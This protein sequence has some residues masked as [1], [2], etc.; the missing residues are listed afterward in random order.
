MDIPFISE[1]DIITAFARLNDKKFVYGPEENGGV[2][3]IGI[4]APYKNGIFKKIRWSTSNSFNDL[5]V[6]SGEKNTFSLKLKNDLNLPEDILSLKD[7]ISHNC[8]IL[9]NFLC[10]SGY[11]FSVKN[12]YVNFDDL[13]I[14]IPVV[15]NIIQK[16]KKGEIEILIQTRYKP[17]FDPENTGKLEIPSGLIKKNELAQEAAVRE[18]EEETGIISEVS[19]EQEVLDYIVSKK[20]N[21]VAVYKPFCCHQQLKGDRAYISL[22]FISNYRK[23]ELREG[24]QET[25]NPRWI[26]LDNIK[27]I[28][29]KN[30]D[31]IFSLSLAVLKEYLRYLNK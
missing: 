26:S 20:G 14:C 1:E 4:R 7:E 9:Y 3:L 25:R 22:A 29:N 30:P 12:K 18:T 19:K 5:I 31:K 13:S 21:I 16:E 17:T 11:Y 24:F 6:N 10:E 23:G 8:P 15:S 2:Y 27:K 28:I